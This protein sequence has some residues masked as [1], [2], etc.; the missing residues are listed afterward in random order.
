MFLIGYMAN[1]LLQSHSTHTYN[2]VRRHL[3]FKGFQ[4][5]HDSCY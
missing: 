2:M 5:P 1:Y 4:A 3:I